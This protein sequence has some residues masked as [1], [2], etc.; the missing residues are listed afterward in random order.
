MKIT[1]LTDLPELPVSHDPQL[2]KRVM[3]ENG[4]IP[5]ITGFSQAVIPAGESVSDHQHESMTE[6]MFVA[7]GEGCIFVD[8]KE[9][10][11][12]PGTCVCVEPKEKH[13]LRNTGSVD[14]LLLYF[15][16]V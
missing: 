8:E 7:A 4:V 3:I 12:I 5:H 11:L 15:G 9:Y 6:V 1:K 10:P 16:V 13:S 14:L 2:K